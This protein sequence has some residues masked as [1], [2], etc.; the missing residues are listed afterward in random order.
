MKHR[1][2][3]RGRWLLA[4]GAI[5]GL[6]MLAVLI[7]IR[8]DRDAGP[9]DFGAPL[10]TQEVP[11]ASGPSVASPTPSPEASKGADVQPRLLQIPRLGV[12]AR[13]DPV[14]VAPDGETEVPEDA[15]RVGW[16]RFGPAPGSSEGSAVIVGHVD[17]RTQGLGV[18]AKLD[19]VRA[20][21]RVAV[22]ASDG[23]STR[24]RIVSRR[25]VPKDELAASGV[26]RRDGSP[27]LTLITC[28]GP[29]LKDRGG[30]QDN[31]VI[32]AVPE[33]S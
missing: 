12:N 10:P 21:D 11:G 30:Y 29:F 5:L 8:L 4:T 1:R 33:T 17:S 7:V 27:A 15:R 9:A 6:A 2:S 20:D 32:T 18:L 24:Y 13:I 28:T 16:Y 23:S 25:T 19:D 26:F 14:G 3:P 31:L 22:R